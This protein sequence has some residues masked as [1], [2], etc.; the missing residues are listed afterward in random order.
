MVL[1]SLDPG[2]PA[3]YYLIHNTDGLHTLPPLCLVQTFIDFMTD[4]SAPAQ[5]SQV[6]SCQE[7]KQQETLETLVSSIYS[8]PNIG[9]TNVTLKI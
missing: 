6:I 8:T 3:E 5:H 4:Y 1:S 9:L 7:L 2:R